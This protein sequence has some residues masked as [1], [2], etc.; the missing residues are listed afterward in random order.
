MHRNLRTALP[1]GPSVVHTQPWGAQ[2]GLAIHRAANAGEGVMRDIRVDLQERARLIEDQISVAYAQFEKLIEQLQAEREG[3]VSELKS[4]LSAL[5]KLMEAE[6]RRMANVL[7]LAPQAP[8]PQLS[9][10]PQLSQGPQSQQGSQLSLSDFIMHSLNEA[11]AMSKDEI[12]NLALKD[13]YFADGESAD[14]GVQAALV[15]LH[16]NEHIRQLPDGSFA[17]ATL[18]QTIRFRRAM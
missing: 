14:R 8:A 4:E 11:G 9:P 12:L 6:H 1:S 13:G 16:R 3:R 18:S 5:G 15:I 2:C 10:G 7:P 17:P